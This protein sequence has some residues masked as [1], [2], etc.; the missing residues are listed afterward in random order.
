MSAYSASGVNYQQLDPAKIIFQN[1]A[2]AT[3]LLTR[4]E[5]LTRPLPWTRGES[6]FLHRIDGSDLCLAHVHETLGTKNLV[7]DAMELLTGRNYYH[8]IGQ[9]GVAMVVNDMITLGALPISVAMHLSAGSSAWFKDLD[10][11]TNLAQGWAQACVFAG[12]T[13]AGG[14]TPALTDI[15]MPDVCELSGSALGV[16]HEDHIMN[17]LHLEQGDEMVFLSNP[18]LGA[19][20][21]TLAR[22]IS[23]LLDEGYLTKIDN[24]GT[25]YGEALL[26]PT[27]I[28]VSALRS[29]QRNGLK[30]VYGVN[31]TGHGML[32]LMRAPQS[33]T[34]RVTALP[35]KTPAVFERIQDA[36]KIS[37]EE[38][39]ST[40][41]M[42]IGF[43]FFVK[44][45]E[46]G[47]AVDLLAKAGFG[48]WRGGYVGRAGTKQVIIEELGVVYKG[49][50]LSIR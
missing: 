42:G 14:E 15:L 20:G 27:P 40:Y 48:A 24:D 8:G 16:V 43:V 44:N 37:K 12:A 7:A 46:A 31:V 34:Y 50:Q 5:A 3:E 41:N 33:F 9:D 35:V 10:R 2:A 17:P 23:Y 18:G 22:E 45:G 4:I 49:A 47:T 26:T 39:Y 29:L 6:C 25:T 32:K 21:F 28:Y 30:P 11:V 1:A 36:K 38:M 13:W 19:N